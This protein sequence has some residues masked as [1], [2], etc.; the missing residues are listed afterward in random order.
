MGDKIVVMNHGTVEQFGVPQQIYDWPATL[1]VAD[2]IGSPSMNLL[3]F[4]GDIAVG[5][6]RVS[7]G[8][9]QF[10]VP[11]Q[12]QAASGK[13]VL[14]VRPEH[15]SLNNDSAYRGT[16][17]A[18]EYLGTTQIIT[19]DTPGGVLKARVQATQS[20]IVDEE[21][22]IDFDSSTITLFD[23]SSGAALL[24]DANKGVLDHG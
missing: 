12:L 13:L 6:T 21:M 19:F 22:G 3:H 9:Q 2:F 1:F 8:E 15:V 17:L 11:K 23:E 5:D 14:G 7:L 10:E 20:V 18:A 4:S 24:S 16:V